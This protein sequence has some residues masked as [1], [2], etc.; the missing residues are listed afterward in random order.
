MTD[1]SDDI[2]DRLVAGPIV[3]YLMGISAA[4]IPYFLLGGAVV[5]SLIARTSHLVICAAGGFV[6]A[7]MVSAICKAVLIKGEGGGKETDRGTLENVAT[8]FLVLGLFPTI[9]VIADTFFQIP[10]PSELD[11]S[12]DW[13]KRLYLYR[14]L[15]SFAAPGVFF[16]YFA[17]KLSRRIVAF[18]LYGALE[19]DIFSDAGATDER[20]EQ[21]WGDRL[22]FEKWQL[23]STYFEKTSKYFRILTKYPPHY[24]P[25]EL[26]QDNY[27][28]LAAFV[29][30][31]C[32]VHGAPARE[33]LNHYTG[34]QADESRWPEAFL[35]RYPFPDLRQTDID[36]TPFEA[37]QDFLLG[38]FGDIYRITP[39]DLQLTSAEI[40]ERIRV[41][42][43]EQRKANANSR[44]QGY[45]TSPVHE[46]PPKHIQRLNFGKV[47]HEKYC[48]Y[49]WDFENMLEKL[50]RTYDREALS[51]MACDQRHLVFGI[52]PEDER[53]RLYPAR[54]AYDCVV[55]YGEPLNRHVYIIGK[56][57][58]G[59]TT[60]LR[61]L[62]DQHIGNEQ[63][64]V[65]LSPENQLFDD[66]LD[67]VPP[68][69]ARDVVYFDPVATE[70][71]LVSFGPF[72]IEEGEMLFERTGEVYSVLEAAMGDLGDSMKGLLNKCVYTLLQRPG[73]TLQDLGRLLKP[74][75]D[76]RR[77][78]I[79]DP[80]ID[81]ETR[82]WWRDTYE[83]KGS[84]LPVS[85]EAIIRRLDAFFMPP[86]SETTSRPSFSLTE[87]LN[88]QKSIF[89]FNLSRLKG[90]QAE[91]LGQ[92]LISSVLQALLA[93]DKQP[94]GSFLPYHFVIDEFQTYAGTSAKTFIEMFNRARKYRMSITLAHQVTANIPPELLSTIIGNAGTKVV[95]ERPSED[96]PFFA[97]ELQ[98][99]TPDKE[100]FNAAVL[101]NLYPHE[102][103]LQTPQNK[104]GVILK[105]LFDLYQPI[106]VPVE[107]DELPEGYQHTTVEDLADWRRLLKDL[108][109]RTYGRTLD[110]VPVSASPSTRPEPPPSEPDDPESN[111]AVT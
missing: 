29:K 1:K 73:S 49:R 79:T 50:A 87:A 96:A 8:F 100:T 64:L 46:R 98:L 27:R 51:G 72:A 16:T 38:V 56:T 41:D 42:L 20:E 19:E 83:G 37:V 62:I 36:R 110:T 63:G 105:T 86:L 21:L 54:S 61:T 93:R 74:N 44:A 32:A 13:N 30:L 75:G 58:A 3:R 6:V 90:L 69:R 2:W 95:M 14:V 84:K 66:V 31:L 26:T 7:V 43:Q 57:G 106:D 35:Q 11:M 33:A 4:A 109:R 23:F 82:E 52:P 103:F 5:G 85:A 104:K 94:A 9:V 71:P 15:F 53:A 92:L 12:S 65:I 76:F 68:F 108:S 10:L 18:N 67:G 60:L 45:P 40:Q 39:Q 48:T 97:K 99:K 17:H 22:R 55:P 59:K 47:L 102:F 80:R 77:A 70:A 81:S 78:I 24:L 107:S 91:V 88:G 34:Q 28:R 111:F 101:Q 25:D 89:L